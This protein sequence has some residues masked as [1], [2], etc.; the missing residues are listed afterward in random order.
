VTES[1][2]RAWKYLKYLKNEYGRDRCG[3][4]AA[5]LAFGTLLSIVPLAALLTWLLRPYDWSLDS[6][7]D[8]LSRYFLPTPELQTIILEAIERYAG[9]AGAMGLFG[10]AF[11]LF[12]A[13]GMLMSVES[14]FNDIWHVENRRGQVHKLG[15]FWVAVIFAPLLFIV[16]ATLNQNLSRSAL[17]GSLAENGH[18]EWL[19]ADLVPFLL[20]VT[21]LSLGY[22]LLPHTSVRKR[23]AIF[24]ALVAAL[25]Y[26]LARWVF[27]QYLEHIA[28]FDTIYGILGVIPAFLMWLF[29]VWSVVLIGA[30]VSYTVDRPW[31]E[32][33]R[34]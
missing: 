24:G 29:F 22:L 27:V 15:T 1:L 14:I 12:V 11:F 9:N 13:W 28:T 32:L 4:A 7:L 21:S 20:L 16:G 30:E 26:Q 17:F 5:A 19:I 18:F 25:L 34:G 31:E 3:Q 23:A 8:F 33:E 6:V 2:A 10:L